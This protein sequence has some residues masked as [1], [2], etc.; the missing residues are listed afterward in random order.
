MLFDW[1]FNEYRYDEVMNGKPASY[2]DETNESNLTEVELRMRI[3][4][5][6]EE[7]ASLRDE[8]VRYEDSATLHERQAYKIQQ[9]L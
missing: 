1:E 5:L 3:R 2:S 6:D 9:K 4:R 7:N 8:L